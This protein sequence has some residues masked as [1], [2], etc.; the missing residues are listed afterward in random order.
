M[1]VPAYSTPQPGDP[2]TVAI[3]LAALIAT[4]SRLSDDVPAH[5]DADTTA[6]AACELLFQLRTE[7]QRL[8]TVEAFVEAEAADRMPGKELR[9]DGYVAER[10]GGTAKPGNWR[11]DDVA[12]V[13]CREAA[14]DPATG[15]LDEGALQVVDR[16]RSLLL[17]A[18]RPEWRTTVLRQ[19]GI[20]PYDYAERVPSRRT[21]TIREDTDEDAA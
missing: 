18:A 2:D 21:V 6:E 15:E 12:W 20:D 19:H 3:D 14:V 9:W 7:R 10:R 13:L 8:Q 4:V 5:L 11:H 16:V 17:N 1:T